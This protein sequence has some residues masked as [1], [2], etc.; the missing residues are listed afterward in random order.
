MKVELSKNPNGRINSIKFGLWGIADGLVRVA[1][2]G[3]LRTSFQMSHAKKVAKDRVRNE[4][5]RRN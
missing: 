2:L 1:S 5:S 4:S 3:S